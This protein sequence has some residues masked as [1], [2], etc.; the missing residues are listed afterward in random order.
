MKMHTKITDFIA[1]FGKTDEVVNEI[2]RLLAP[3]DLIPRVP[4]DRAIVKTERSDRF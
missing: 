4:G 1:H 3:V 2:E